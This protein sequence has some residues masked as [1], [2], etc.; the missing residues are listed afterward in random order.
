[1]TYF[2]CVLMNLDSCACRNFVTLIEL[3]MEAPE[4]Q[5]GSVSRSLKMLLDLLNFFLEVA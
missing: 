1:M 3:I 5:Y 4:I 2:V